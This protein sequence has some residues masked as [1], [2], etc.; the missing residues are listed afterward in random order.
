MILYQIAS[1]LSIEIWHLMSY[2]MYFVQLMLSALLFARTY[3][4]RRRYALRLIGM[5]FCGLILV[6]GIARLRTGISDDITPQL[7]LFRCLSYFCILAFAFFFLLVCY[8]EQPFELA[9]CWASVCAACG[10]FTNL[11]YA[12]VSLTGHDPMTSMTIFPTGDWRLDFL[13]HYLLFGAYLVGMSFL[14]VR[15]ARFNANSRDNAVVLMLCIGVVLIDDVLLNVSRP[16]EPESAALALSLRLG[17]LLCFLL[18]FGLLMG[19]IKWNRL[20]EELNITEQLLL[21]EKR[22]YQQSKA[23]VEAVNRML[24][25]LKHRLS[26]IEGKLTE[27]ELSSMRQAMALY[28]ANIKTGYEVLDTILYEKQLYCQKNGVRLTCMA[29]GQS[30]AH[31]TPSHLYSLFDNAIDNA[32][33][34]VLRLPDPESRIVSVTV[35]RENNAAE[36]VVCNLFDPAAGHGTTSKPDQNRHGYGLASMRTIAENYG[37]TMHI[38]TENDVFTLTV[39]LPERS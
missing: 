14:F 30:L 7:L 4:R 28:D 5:V 25:D 35:T 20:G 10:I 36:I 23:N 6:L 29:D 22:Y 31:L 11:D 21:R 32:M 8:R 2:L 12:L 34:A 38:S 17:V 9:I 3:E 15:R 24:H 1:A 39:R 16:F 19:L 33:E 13:L 37:G 18:A 26:D 27:E